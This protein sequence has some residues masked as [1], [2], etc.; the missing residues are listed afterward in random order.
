[1]RR[2]VE[3]AGGVLRAGGTGEGAGGDRAALE[4]GGAGGGGR[5]RGEDLDVRARGGGGEAGAGQQCPFVHGG[6]GGGRPLPSPGGHQVLLQGGLDPLF[7]LAPALFIAMV[8]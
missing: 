2:G 5:T 3:A 4:R 7:H 1:M 8:Y 6:C